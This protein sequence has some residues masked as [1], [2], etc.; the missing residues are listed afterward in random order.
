M[1]KLYLLFY[2]LVVKN[3]PMQ[4]MPG[5]RL[6]EKIR[7]FFV[8]RIILKCGKN[9]RIN[10]N[11]YFG[12]GNRL[13]IGDRTLLGHNARMGGKITLGNDVIMAPDIIMMAVSHE[14][15]DIKIPINQQ[16]AKEE[17]EIIIEDDVWLGTRVIVMPGVKIGA[18][19]IVGSGAVVTKS[20][21]EYSIIGG[22]PAKFIKS[23]ID[24]ELS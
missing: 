20:F 2:Y 16:G 13:K 9:V 14:Y 1:K 7:Y 11:C 8:S 23:R 21:P 19:S 17:K 3:L 24:N 10:A 6:F 22:I 4:P 5:W 12:D 18:H 15:K